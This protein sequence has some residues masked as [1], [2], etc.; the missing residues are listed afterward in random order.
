MSNDNKAK[1]IKSFSFYI[2]NLNKAL[3]NIKSEVMADFVCIDQAGI[4]IVTN[5]VILSLD[6][7][8]I[9]KYIKNTNHINTDKVNTPYLSQSKSYLKIIGIFY[10]LENTNILF[11]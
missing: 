9:K 10:F 11:C 2:T 5:K 6:L 4:T 8:T 7:Q 3:K 1:F